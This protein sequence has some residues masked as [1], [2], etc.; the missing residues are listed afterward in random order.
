MRR[1]VAD[2][3]RVMASRDL[4]SKKRLLRQNG[5]WPELSQEEKEANVEGGF[6]PFIAVF[7]KGDIDRAAAED[8]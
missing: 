6:A 5:E 3:A 2:V 7:E 1:S 4:F 8:D